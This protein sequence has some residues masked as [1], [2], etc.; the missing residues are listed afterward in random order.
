MRHSP[1]IEKDNRAYTDILGVESPHNEAVGTQVR[2]LRQTTASFSTEPSSV[3]RNSWLCRMRAHRRQRKY[4]L[5]MTRSERYAGFTYC[6]SR[7]PSSPYPSNFVA[8]V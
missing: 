4:R 1:D 3:S 5:L 6:T 8:V 7:K 2:H